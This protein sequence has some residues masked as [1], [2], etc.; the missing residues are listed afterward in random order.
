[1]SVGVGR[2]PLAEHYQPDYAA[3]VKRVGSLLL[4]EDG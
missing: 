2:E 4:V 1:M 3:T